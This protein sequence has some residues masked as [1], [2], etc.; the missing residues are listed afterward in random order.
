M[1]KRIESKV[2]FSGV[3]VLEFMGQVVEKHTKHYRSDFEI[4]KEILHQAADSGAQ[5]D[6]TFIWLC[7][8]HGT[9]CL[10]E[11]NVFLKDTREYSTF[12]FYME[13]TSEPILAFLIEI[14]SGTQDSVM[15]NVYVLD[16]AAYYSHVHSVSLNAE[17]VLMQYESGCRVRKADERIYG[18]P[19]A[20]YGKLVSVQYQPHSEEELTGLLQEERRKGVC[21]REGCANAYISRLS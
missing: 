14:I 6:K 1:A 2:K 21:Y 15:G 3:D 7:R 12:S 18:Y 10:L 19:D 17:T 20:E 4:D 8:T 9:W 11:R 5:Q 16:Y 13:Q